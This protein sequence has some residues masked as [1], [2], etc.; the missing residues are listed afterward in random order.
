MIGINS[1]NNV[2][3]GSKPYIVEDRPMISRSSGDRGEFVNAACVAFLIYFFSTVREKK[4]ES[5]Q[6]VPSVYD[7]YH[8]P[9]IFYSSDWEKSSGCSKIADCKLQLDIYY[10]QTALIYFHLFPTSL[11]T[12]Q[13][14]NTSICCLCNNNDNNDTR[15]TATN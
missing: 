9:A 2:V 15:C 13:L 7:I 10:C 12:S 4:R 11:C 5:N 14:F 1:N 8:L 6:I 3:D